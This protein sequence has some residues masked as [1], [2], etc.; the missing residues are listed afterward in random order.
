MMRGDSSWDRRRKRSRALPAGLPTMTEGA[1]G[2]MTPPADSS[3]YSSR[4]TTVSASTI[5]SRV[6]LRRW[7][8]MFWSTSAA[9][10]GSVSSSTSARCS[11]SSCSETWAASSSVRCSSMS[12]VS[13]GGSSSRI[14]CLELL[15]RSTRMSP[16]SAGCRAF[17]SSRASL[18]RSCSRRSRTR[19]MRSLVLSS[20]SAAL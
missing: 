19:S 6:G 17:R 10:S 3:G 11:V 20:L 5:S 7:S 4:G 18:T 8:G 1:S 12:A 14:S 15:G 16:W 2:S 9:T 13:S